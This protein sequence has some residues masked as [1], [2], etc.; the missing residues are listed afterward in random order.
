MEPADTGF[1]SA[2]L[3]EITAESARFE[4]TKGS[5]LTELSVSESYYPKELTPLKAVALSTNSVREV[6]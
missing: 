2:K 6:T 1:K 3:S 4:K 5:I